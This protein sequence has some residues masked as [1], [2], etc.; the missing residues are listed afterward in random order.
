MGFKIAIINTNDVRFE[1]MNITYN[2]MKK[3]KIYDTFS[4]I[5]TLKNVKNNDEFM[6]M[7][8]EEITPN[9]NDYALHTCNI[10]YINNELYQMCHILLT[11]QSYDK[12]K[13]D[14]L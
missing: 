8:I 5:I 7:I 4:D 3:E 9:S 2:S 14:S 10:R 12:I 1:G 13:E 11:E 6:N